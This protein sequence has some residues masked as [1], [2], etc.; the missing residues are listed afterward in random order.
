[1]VSST[2]RLGS[3]GGTSRL[4]SYKDDKAYQRPSSP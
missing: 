1:M 4:K 2:R 3:A